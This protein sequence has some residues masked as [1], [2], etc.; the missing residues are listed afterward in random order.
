[1]NAEEKIFEEVK[2]YIK[3]K[4][5]IK[6]IKVEEIE[7]SP[8]QLSDLREIAEDVKDI[9][10]PYDFWG[11]NKKY[12]NWYKAE[13]ET[14]EKEINNGSYRRDLDDYTEL[15]D[16]YEKVKL[17][18]RKINKYYS[19]L[20]KE[21][22][23][24]SD[25]TVLDEF[26][27]EAKITKTEDFDTSILDNYRNWGIDRVCLDGIQNHLPDD[28]KGTNC[29]IQ[30][31]ID[32][33]WVSISEAKLQKDKIT[34]IRFADDGV[35]FSSKNLKFLSS[36][37]TSEDLSAGQFGEG[38]KLIAMNCVNNGFDMEVQSKNWIAKAYGKDQIVENYRSGDT[39]EEQHKQLAWKVDI[40][41]KERIKGSRTIFNHPSK[42][43]IDYTFKLEEYVWALTGKEPILSNNLCE[44][45]SVENGGMGFSKGIYVCDINTLF[46]YSFNDVNLNPDRNSF[47]N[48][49]NYSVYS[50]LRECEDKELIKKMLKK[51]LEFYNNNEKIQTEKQPYELF[52]ATHFNMDYESY[53]Y[54]KENVLKN[55][56]WGKALK[57]I[58]EEEIKEKGLEG[59]VLRTDFNLSDSMKEELKKYKCI[60][61]PKEWVEFFQM[62]GIKTDKEV[63]PDYI[64]EQ[65]KTSI[66]LDYG[67]ELWDEERILLDACQ[68]HLPKDSG[69]TNTF[70]R[71]QTDDGLWHDYKEFPN[72]KDEQI[73]IIKICDNGK[74]FDYKSLGLFASIKDHDSSGGKWGEGLKMI[75]AS[76]VRNGIK[77]EVRS[78]NWMAVPIIEN[79]ILN[80]G[81]LNEKEV[82]RLSFNVKVNTKDDKDILRDDDKT[83]DKETG[84]KKDEEQS[85]TIF[86]E[87]NAELIKNFRNISEK[88]LYF[89]H[90][91]PFFETK[92]VDLLDIRGGKLY[93]RDILVPGDHHLKYSYNLK[94]FD[95]ETRDR[96]AI[97]SYSMKKNIRT[98]IEN[99]SD[100][101]FVTIFLYQAADRIRKND[102]R[103]FYEFDTEF[104]IES[105]TDKADLWINSFL[106]YFGEESCVRKL[107]D[108]DYDAVA[109]A[110]HMGL[111]T[112]TLPNCIAN[113][114]T[115]LEGS[116]GKKIPTYRDALN[117]AINNAIFVDND[118][119]TDKEKAIIE[120]LY[121]YNDVLAL[122]DLSP[123]KIKNI[124]VYDYDPN[125]EGKRAAG[126]AK[127]GEEI[128]ISRESLASGLEYATHVFFHES[129]HAET[130]AGDTDSEF[131]NYQTKLLAALT[132][133]VLPLEKSVIDNGLAKNLPF[134]KFRNFIK[135]FA[136][137]QVLKE[138][139]IKNK[140]IEEE[141][142]YDR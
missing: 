99:M 61:L 75:A 91:K 84:Y 77:M 108:L 66:T 28:S 113:V 97:K 6:Q 57:E 54:K 142:G 60:D 15:L 112:I 70:L 139:N 133:R 3:Y 88:I 94:N 116:D 7:N 18:L 26:D 20:E 33:K 27:N 13:H 32:D 103:D 115:G 76:A 25:E 135:K 83:E 1:M 81:E 52:F 51:M 92:D 101:R 134:S 49:S 2:K 102:N 123:N 71:F 121:K 22:E 105:R 106:Q 130:G 128:S 62:S 44:L 24:K 9:N 10:L 131:R 53:V 50:I 19:L 100:E 48:L 79:E 21:Q 68:N 111:Q 36:Q 138:K 37:K 42:E 30:Y 39:Y 14:L 93:I 63:I 87:P 31:L 109:Q 12:Y 56:L 78:R 67:S 107:T 74:G 8:Y 137:K 118:K 72:F 114:L 104:G 125:Y 119:L 110:E 80:Q 58:F 47:K 16:L 73:K 96:D 17:S 11:Y 90:K 124:K 122:S 64:E 46:S 86:I 5:L 65:V 4:L 29:F 132:T 82:Q 127:F 59:I 95:I 43:L 55:Y 40:Y 140:D 120:Q 69:G 141:E 89:S 98:I 136:W 34:K 45:L 129:G 85:S 35:G 23:E 38:L 126:F 41:D 117:E